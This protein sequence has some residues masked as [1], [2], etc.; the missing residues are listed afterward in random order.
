MTGTFRGDV[1]DPKAEAVRLWNTDPCGA[2]DAFSA[3]TPA[4]FDAVE[5]MR[6]RDYAPWL[7]STLQ[8]HRYMG[9]AVLEIGCGLGTDL[10]QFARAGARVAAVDLTP[11][12]LE[13][14]R[15]RLL[16]EGRTAMLLRSD[17]ERLPIADGTIDLVYSFGVLHHTPGIR[18][19]VQEIC[20]VLKPD[21]AA[22]VAL[23]HKQSLFFMAWM[24]R[25]IVTG[26]LWRKGYRSVMA[27]IEQHPGSAAQPL[28]TVHTRGSARRL[29]SQFRRVTIE[30]H[31][32]AYAAPVTHVA[33]VLQLDDRSL[34]TLERLLRRAGWYLVIRAEK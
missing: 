3:G 22:H 30:T 14:T 5:A 6:Y 4:F 18:T 21:G 27:D 19:A 29:F 8:P 17:A 15:R 23:Y 16:N 1:W 10:V 7:L 34:R 32:A 26:A 20:R 9:K 2:T 13:L 28:V 31:H 25:A 33:R 11:R 24:A 12:H